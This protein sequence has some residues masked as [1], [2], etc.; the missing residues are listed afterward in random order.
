MNKVRLNRCPVCGRDQLEKYLQCTD[1]YASGETYHIVSCK[2]CGFRFTQDFPDES[3]MGRYYETPDYVSHSDTKKGIVN[4]LYHFVRS[5]MIGRKVRMTEEQSR[6]NR[7]AILDI[8]CGTGYYLGSM[9]KRGWNTLGVEKSQM[10]ASAARNH[11]GLE[12]LSDLKEISSGREFDVISLWHVLE[13]LQD[14]SDVFARLRLHLKED[15]KLI[16]ALPNSNSYDALYYGKY[17]GAY[18]V[19]RHL[20]HFTPSTFGELAAKEGFIIERFAPMPFDAFYVSMLSERYQGNRNTFLRGM[21][22]GLIALRYS[23][24]DPQRSSSIIYILRRKN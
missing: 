15:G 19:P 20:W 21:I 23:L 1:H 4:Q 24:S 22:R 18:D 6:K 14:L 11:F 13:H 17:W 7:G 8:G 10:A 9:K 12:V 16:I 3:V 2:D 5:Y